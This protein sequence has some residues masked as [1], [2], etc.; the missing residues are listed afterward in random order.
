MDWQLGLERRRAAIEADVPRQIDPS[1]LPPLGRLGATSAR[2][3]S[4]VGV[5]WARERRS[6]DN[7]RLLARRLRLAAERLGP[8]YIKLAQ[9][10]SAGEGLFPEP[11]VEEFK[12]CRDR[13][14][15]EP[16]SDIERV[17]LEEL[18]FPIDE[19]FAEFDS[20][21]MAAASIAQVHR[22]VLREPFAGAGREVVVKVQR[23]TVAKHVDRDL[24]VLAWIAMR[25]VGRIPVASLANP[26]ALVE[27]FAHTISEELDFRIE[28]QNM[29]DVTA[30]LST[31]EQEGFIVPRP[32]PQLVTRRVLVMERLDGYAFDDS[33]GVIAAGIDTHQIIRNG[34][35]GFL[36]GALLHGVFHGDLHPGNLFITDSGRTALLDFGITGRLGQAQR[37]AFLRLMLSAT[38]ADTKGQLAALR[39]LGALPPDTDLDEMIDELD[40]DQPIPDPLEMDQAEMMAELKRMMTG[41]LA[42]GARIPKE[43]MLFIKNMI[44]V[45]AAIQNLAPDLDL[46]A[47]VSHVAAHFASTHGD[48]LARQIGFDADSYELDLDPLKDG[49]G[50]SHDTESFTYAELVER[51][52]LIR[53]RLSR[54]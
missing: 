46:L 32:H 50:I 45:D 7:R 14:A 25:M 54:K 42:Y 18:Q 9:V 6:A 27:L 22:A 41:M 12:L 8:T 52:D 26:P 16:F 47:E 13:V 30:M 31:F 38:T 17:L 3:A 37:Q 4:A 1:H 39:D 43:L 53:D 34:M 28:A 35:V 40:L 10:I 48:E 33:E 2:L 36:E 23:P 29:L 44:F 51:R 20:T 21:P 11:I 24:G 19:V 5:W 49:L 15:P